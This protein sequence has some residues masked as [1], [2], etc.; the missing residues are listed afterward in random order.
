[1]TNTLLPGYNRPVTHVQVV[2][3]ELLKIAQQSAH[4][5]NNWE[6]ANGLL[7]MAYGCEQRMQT[8]PLKAV[9][10]RNN[11]RILDVDG[12]YPVSNVKLVM[13]EDIVTYTATKPDG[14]VSERWAGMETYF[15]KVVG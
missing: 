4:R 5:R 8:K 9:L 2:D 15:D 14:S 10:L 11:D 1:M 3:R 13:M 12:L 7:R 6:C